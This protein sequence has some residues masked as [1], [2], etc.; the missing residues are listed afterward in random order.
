MR[1]EEPHNPRHEKKEVGFGRAGKQD[2]VRRGKGETGRGRKKG[3]KQMRR[4]RRKN[5]T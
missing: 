5:S 3:K 4:Y 1:V 2:Y